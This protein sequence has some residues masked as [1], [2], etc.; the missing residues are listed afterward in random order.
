MA[1]DPAGRRV[2][3]RRRRPLHVVA[4]GRRCPRTGRDFPAAR[5]RHR[6]A[7]GVP[8]GRHGRDPSD[9]A[10]DR[11]V[12]SVLA[13]RRG[14]PAPSGA[15]ARGSGRASA[16]GRART[17][18]GRGRRGG[19]ARR[20]DH[21]LRH[22]HGRPLVALPAHGVAV[23]HHRRHRAGRRGL[24]R[25]MGSLRHPPARPLARERLRSGPHPRNPAPREHGLPRATHRAHEHR[26]DRGRDPRAR[27]P[28]HRVR[29]PAGLAGGR[30][31]GAR[32]RGGVRPRSARARRLQLQR[33]PARPGSVDGTAAPAGAGS[34]RPRPARRDAGGRR[35]RGT[36]SRRP[37]HRAA[38]A[39]RGAS[40]RPD[41]P[42]KRRRAVWRAA[43][44]RGPLDDRPHARA[45]RPVLPRAPAQRARHHHALRGHRARVVVPISPAELPLRRPARDRSRAPLPGVAAT[46]ADHARRLRRA[47]AR[48]GRPRTRRPA[49][50][51]PVGD[52]VLA[53]ARPARADADRPARLSEVVLRTTGA[54]PASAFDR[55]RRGRVR[56]L[57]P[58]AV[59][60]GGGV[61][62]GVRGSAG[63]AA[64][65]DAADRPPGA[66]G[67]LPTPGRPR[68]SADRPDRPRVASAHQPLS[69]SGRL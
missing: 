16:P 61:R 57:D 49:G 8:R 17:A 5:H 59:R 47:R 53:A 33:E 62:R 60:P 19:L 1:A 22:R 28:R 55:S 43:G 50:P 31:A 26:R 65:H 36:P 66:R 45:R 40:L 25:R 63:A 51:P 39:A 29:H 34:R 41:R 68:R 46:A 37:P 11:A 35:D 15:A 3:R 13:A 48:S 32:D 9:P 67:V 64:R 52:P 54:G 21:A 6:R 12:V 20:H 24:G 27:L 14:R 30:D 10:P 4:S 69:R 18:V 56:R 38:H 44:R 23:P 7:H 58:P 2:G 42:Q